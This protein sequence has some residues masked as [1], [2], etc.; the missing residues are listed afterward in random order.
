MKNLSLKEPQNNFNEYLEAIK[1]SEVINIFLNGNAIVKL[2]P[3]NKDYVYKTDSLICVIKGEY[4][5]KEKYAKYD[6]YLQ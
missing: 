6:E 1:N 3:Y 2:V 5:Y 4:D